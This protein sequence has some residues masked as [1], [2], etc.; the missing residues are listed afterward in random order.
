MKNYR[1][2]V[3]GTTYEVALEEID[4]SQVKAAPAPEVKKAE[5]APAPAKVV[6]EEPK[7]ASDGLDLDDLLGDIF[8]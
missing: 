3:N 1:V 8:G 7:K 4:A 5:A 6:K 2:I